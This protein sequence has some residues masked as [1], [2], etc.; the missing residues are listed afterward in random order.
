[1][2][3]TFPTSATR[4]ATLVLGLPLMLSGCANPGNSAQQ[5][6]AASVAVAGPAAEMITPQLI[7]AEQGK[8]DAAITRDLSRL[9]V[10]RPP[11][12]T[13]DSGDIVSIVVWEHPELVGTVIKAAPG[14]EPPPA[15]VPASGFE[16]DPK[17]LLRFPFAG[18]IKLG[19]LTEDQA[20]RPAREKAG[21]IHRRAQGRRAGALLPQQAGVHRRRGW[22]ARPAND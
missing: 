15:G 12:Y 1:M 19:G 16:V 18:A 20:R 8:R 3:I 11:A 6:P 13:I 22:L 5:A 2:K 14:A 10:R 21:E 4:V 17:G 7:A 9:M